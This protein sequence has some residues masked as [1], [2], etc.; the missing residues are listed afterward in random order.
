MF[1]FDQGFGPGT[2]NGWNNGVTPNRYGPSM[3]GRGPGGMMRGWQQPT[4]PQS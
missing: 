2:M 4:L 1:N 3:M